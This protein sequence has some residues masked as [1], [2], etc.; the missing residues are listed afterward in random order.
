MK[1]RTK[2]LVTVGSILAAL[3]FTD[4]VLLI[5]GPISGSPDGR[6][7]AQTRQLE[8]EL[9]LQARRAINSEEFEEAAKFFAELRE[10]IVHPRYAADSYYWEAFARYRLDDLDEALLLLETLSVYDEA[11]DGH[12]DTRRGHVPPGR[13]HDEW[14]DLRIRVLRQLAERGDPRAAEEAFRQAEAVLQADTPSVTLAALRTRQ[15]SAQRAYQRALATQRERQDS[16]QRAFQEALTSQRTR[17]DSAHRTYQRALALE[18]SRADSVHRAYQRA[19]YSQ[20]SRADSAQRSFQR[21]ASRQRSWADSAQR[22]YQRTLTRQ[23]SRADSAQRSYQRALYQQRREVDSA[24]RAYQGALNT[25]RTQAERARQLYERALS[26]RRIPPDSAQRVYDVALSVQNAGRDS[27]TAVY[28]A[29]LEGRQAAQDSASAVY[30]AALEAQRVGQDSAAAAYRAALAVFEA[31]QDSVAA[32]YRAALAAQEEAKDS[33]ARAYRAALAAK[34]AREDSAASVYRAAL[35]AEEAARE[36]AARA[37]QAAIAGEPAQPDT[38]QAVPPPTP[39]RPDSVAPAL[40]QLRTRVAQLDS[41]AQNLA[42]ETGEADQAAAALSSVA[43]SLA[44][45]TYALRVDAAQIDP[46]QVI[47]VPQVDLPRLEAELLALSQEVVVAGQQVP[48]GCEDASV[49]QAALTALLRLETREADRLRFILSVLESTDQCS[50]NLRQQAVT[51]LAGQRTG[52]AQRVLVATATN[53]PEPDTRAAA[54]VALASFNTTTAVRALAD[55]LT[56]SDDADVRMGAIWALM[57]SDQAAARRALMAFARDGSR[58]VDLRNAVLQALGQRNDV[59]TERL[60]ELHGTTG[61]QELETALLMVLGTRAEAGEEAVTNWLFELAMDQEQD[62]DSRQSALEAWS[63]GP[64]VDL[65]RVGRSYAQME[66]SEMKERIFYA[67]YRRTQSNGESAEAVVGKM[68]ELAREESDPGVRTR[69]VYWIGRTGSEQA[70]EFLLEVMRERP[71]PS[72]ATS[73]P[74]AS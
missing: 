16:A 64:S 44:A 4:T 26:Q 37:Y 48:A 14:R 62:S 27:A 38:V 42:Q 40:Q 74:S 57:R 19:L 51:W 47:D 43:D 17:V 22:S 69:A 61:S 1:A 41:T 39:T 71:R 28:L 3:M 59:S 32:V 55:L 67:L 72:S 21:A 20:R 34:E 35:A 53:H 58:P 68:I 7:S 73:V 23:R 8:E 25:H 31:R 70:I 52:E 46:L 65:E 54:V 2:A 12:Y 10:R 30:R 60:I 56:E 36:A 11:K 18:R 6:L 5:A 9:F 33:A 50:A 15:E 13:L 45:A 29:V 49:Q 24:Q 66:A 63:R